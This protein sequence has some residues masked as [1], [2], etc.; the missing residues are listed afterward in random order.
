MFRLVAATQHNNPPLSHPLNV[1]PC[2]H[3]RAP[4]LST[5]PSYTPHTVLLL[6]PFLPS[7]IFAHPA[8]R[9]Y[10]TSHE[11][12]DTPRAQV[13]PLNP[14]V[15]SMLFRPSSLPALLSAHSATSLSIFPLLP[16]LLA[17][18]F[19][20]ATAFQQTQGQTLL[21]NITWPFS[22]D[23]HHDLDTAIFIRTRNQQPLLLGY[24]CPHTYALPYA[25]Y[26]GDAASTS[27]WEAFRIDLAVLLPTFDPVNPDF[28]GE[29]DLSA[30]PDLSIEP[31][32]SVDLYPSVEYDPSTDPELT[33]EPNLSDE[34]GLSDEPLSALDDPS[35]NPTESTPPL[36][37]LRPTLSSEP[38][39][40]EDP[41]RSPCHSP[42]AFIGPQEIGPSPPPT[43]P[44][45]PP[46]KSETSANQAPP[47]VEII[48]FA[49]WQVRP[50][51]LPIIVT[52]AL[53][54]SSDVSPAP[55]SS[56][57]P[58]P[59]ALPASPLRKSF[60]V[61]CVARQKRAAVASLTLVRAP[62]ASVSLRADAVDPAVSPKPSPSPTMSASPSP[63]PPGARLQ[64]A[65]ELV[66]DMDSPLRAAVVV[67]V[68]HASPPENEPAQPARVGPHCEA[69]QAGARARVVHFSSLS[70][71]FEVWAE[72]ALT[73]VS[74][75]SAH[76]VV[77]LSVDVLAGARVAGGRAVIFARL[78]DSSGAQLTPFARVSR[79]LGSS[80]PCPRRVVAAAV[81]SRACANGSLS[82]Q[83][84]GSTT[85]NALSRPS[86]PNARVV[87][88]SVDW[89][90][91]SE[92]GSAAAALAGFGGVV[93]GACSAG[94][95]D[96][97][98]A[99]GNGAFEVY[100]DEARKAGLF[101]LR[102]EFGVLLEAFPAGSVATLRAEVHGGETGV[103]EVVVATQVGGGGCPEARAATL[104]VFYDEHTDNYTLSLF[105]KNQAL[106]AIA[107]DSEGVVDNQGDG[108]G[109]R[110]VTSGPGGEIEDPLE[111]H[112][113]V[114]W[115]SGG[116]DGINA[117]ELDT[118]LTF[119]GAA[120]GFPCETRS[121]RF[122][123]AS[124]ESGAPNGTERF[125][126]AA[127]ESRLS[128][129][130]GADTSVEARVFGYWFFARRN[131][132]GG[133]DSANVTAALYR[134]G[135]RVGEEF[136]V[137]VVPDS[138][139]IGCEVGL[140]TVLRVRYDETRDTYA[141][142][143][144]SVDEGQGLGSEVEG[145]ES[146]RGIPSILRRG[147]S[148]RV[149]FSWSKDERDLDSN[150]AFPGETV[151]TT[152]RRFENE[153]YVD[154]LGDSPDRGG[155]EVY[156]IAAGRALD[157]WGMRQAGGG[158]NDVALRIG[159]AAGWFG[160]ES[161]REGVAEVQVA[162]LDMEGRMLREEK[163]AFN[164]FREEA[165]EDCSG[166]KV[167]RVDVFVDRDVGIDARLVIY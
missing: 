159:L 67:R 151:G 22:N 15:P 75:F 8:R 95:T 89:A 86:H 122:A 85:A 55:P 149:S 153:G 114:S 42:R 120:V 142:E 98:R 111:L 128:G 91:S 102:A 46:V 16:F 49:A 2:L 83:L 81:V 53:I 29:P 20:R 28:S 108:Y 6:I 90:P 101:F 72:H 147:E 24:A 132:S 60:F 45:D 164:P 96:F 82:L 131:S 87:T 146:A 97:I 138:G 115:M 152:C 63:R 156:N 14:D 145:G 139:R 78:V 150:V 113:E 129:A 160:R 74:A 110:D 40:P 70:A 155:A 69:V 48:V 66:D 71:L 133:K 124:K 103:S 34:P 58:T 19:T 118:S 77:S 84:E 134:C 43:P 80:A 38:L 73:L 44:P 56:P 3:P 117:N 166:N 31:D 141:M 140:L 9:A 123:F 88:L 25:K 105:P 121:R 163:A 36:S 99:G 109:I 148:L 23:S 13:H 76:A 1:C 157:D 50:I 162:V 30:E 167:G 62:D 47:S 106:S 57:A 17:V 130:W 37:D 52:A 61:P 59:V 35:F 33:S 4:W 5:F 135:A 161:Y 127:E 165:S 126:V 65:V 79:S 94:E 7:L 125:V 26:S 18:L 54:P 51:P 10:L 64:I 104:V 116:D 107:G 11:S 158:W 154:F 41:S 39:Q 92:R 21:I 143:V 144:V 119:L 12:L 68:A 32:V 93:G 27:S 112:V 137:S 136:V 100:V